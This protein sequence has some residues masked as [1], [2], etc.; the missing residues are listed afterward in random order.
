MNI[1]ITMAELCRYRRRPDAACRKLIRCTLCGRVLQAFERVGRC[2]D[3]RQ[4][5]DA[6]RL[7]R[8]D[9]DAGQLTDDTMLA[10]TRGG[11]K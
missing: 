10:A 3:C 9:G 11:G 2:T 6:P 8:R 4:E 1:K 7:N 5:R